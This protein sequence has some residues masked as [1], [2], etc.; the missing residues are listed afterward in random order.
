V[1][2]KGI[3]ARLGRGEGIASV[4]AA[5]GMSRP[6]FDAWWREETGRRVPPH[7]GS[8]PAA[9]RSPARIERDEWGAPHVIAGND[10]DLFF[11]FGVATAQ[12]RLFQLDYLRRK[13]RGRL[14]EVMGSEAV[15]SDLLY[16]TVGLA[17]IAE[18]EWQALPAE[19]RA[20]TEAYSAGIN[21]VI[22]ESR[23][24]APIEF[25]LLEY[26]P[27]PWR[28]TD[29]LAILSEFRWYL[30]GRFPVIVIPELAKRALGEGPL[31]RAFLRTECDDESI[32]ASSAKP[33]PSAGDAGG[34]GSNNWAVSGERTESGKPLVASDP[35][36]PYGA[37]SLWHEVRLRGGSFHVAGVALAGTPGVMIGRTERVAWGITNNICS[38]RDLYQ[39]KTDP[40]HPG[41][42]LY[43]GRWE[44]WTERP[45]VIRVRG[46]DPIRATVRSSRNGPIV[47]GLLPAPARGTGPVSL[48]WLGAAP[49]GW[50]S[51][52]QGMNR[53][54]TCEAFRQAT[55]PWVV[56]TWN[57]VFADV[58][59]HFGFQSVG[60]IPIRPAE[61]RGYRPGWDPKHQWQGLVPFEGMPRD[62]DP[63]RGWVVTANNR[64]AGDDYP[65]PLAG[66]WGSGYRARRIRTC[67][68]SA[69][70]LAVSDCQELQLDVLSG[71]AVE[72]VPRLLALL[73][74]SGDP[75]FRRAVEH[76]RSWDGRM[77]VD[78]VAATVFHAFFVHWCR[79]V[80]AERFPADQV[81][82][83][84]AN[85]AGLA[86]SLLAEGQVGWFHLR[87]RREAIRAAF[88]SALGELTVRLGD[89]VDAWAW[90]RLHS[91]L[92]KHFLSSRGDLGTLLDRS[93]LPVPG[94]STTVCNNT[95]DA[96]HASWLGPGYRMVVDLGDPGKGLWSVEGGSNSGHPGSPHYDDQLRLWHAGGTRYVSLE[97]A[98]ARLV[99]RLEPG[100]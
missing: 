100:S 67:L 42:F 26:E 69:R 57:L 73:G 9:V 19:T 21:A 8:R 93:G 33:R 83:V 16:R 18:A 91:L 43:D 22:E 32:L 34:P 58:D 45:E 63:K 52:L 87:E 48:R 24:L 88:E 29:C 81:D 30:T 61:E 84:S 70:S 59:G 72:N 28:P 85:A 96:N 50:L 38:Q 95:P 36:L 79:V 98:E 80:V 60:R 12:D 44:P 90:G 65:Y 66:R 53:A 41:C 20:L 10:T 6:Q 77:E 7:E 5:A 64:V 92:Q 68:E 25:D 74:D 49:C 82:L 11:A 27:E 89:D 56:P 31:Y 46:A 37:V 4:C 86:A 2:A 99:L 13:A 40:A 23:A 97:G 14:A 71:R 47:D 17:Q 39:E 3:L 35:H 15:E 78:R 94:D 1:N 75:K 51:A 76:L 54:A 62:L 55:R